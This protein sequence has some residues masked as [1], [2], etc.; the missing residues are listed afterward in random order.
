MGAGSGGEQHSASST[1]ILF[2]SGGEQHSASSTKILFSSDGEQHSVLQAL[3]FYLA[4]MVNNTRHQALTY[5]LDSKTFN[6][7][8]LL[9]KPWA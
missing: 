8:E 9:N 1:K 2:S 5:D 6:Y 4:L 7:L 3:K